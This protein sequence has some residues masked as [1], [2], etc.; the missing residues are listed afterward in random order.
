MSDAQK[1]VEYV[2][3]TPQIAQIMLNDAPNLNAMSEVMAGDFR[4][5]VKSLEGDISLC[6]IILTGAGRA[7]SAGGDLA[8]LKG[9]TQLNPAE[10]RAKML[11]F[12][13]SFLGI[14]KLNVPIVAAING[15]AV[16]AGL[17]V[18]CACDVRIAAESAKFG[19]TFVKL[20][21]HPGM[22]A[23]F[24]VSRVVG[25]STAT[26]LMLTGRIIDAT[27]AYRIGL[28]SQI[29]SDAE[30]INSARKIADE[31]A[32]NGRES[33]RQLVRSMRDTPRT[34]DEALKLESAHQA[35]N[36][37]SAEFGARIDAAIAKTKR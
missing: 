13:D 19:F 32:A 30:L 8:M 37:A 27:A 11:D 16:G 28:C 35:V 9:K 25:I 12:Y 36:Y 17:C 6:A 15:H 5:V 24:N 14:L 20:G 26:E 31:I 7:F 22:G 4:A 29:V 10:N 2:R 1:T 34:L 21:L 18:A 23:T 3:L 33:V